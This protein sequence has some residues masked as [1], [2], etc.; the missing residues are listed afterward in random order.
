MTHRGR[1]IAAG[2]VDL[3]FLE[4]VAEQGRER[5][6]GALRDYDDVSCDVCMGLG[7]AARRRHGYESS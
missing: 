2:P 6:E 1:V 7:M 4:R 5:L 3:S